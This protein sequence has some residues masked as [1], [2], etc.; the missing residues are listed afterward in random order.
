METSKYLKSK[1]YEL[2]SVLKVEVDHDCAFRSAP[3]VRLKR[4]QLLSSLASSG[5]SSC[6]TC[7]PQSRHTCAI[8]SPHKIS[9]HR[10]LNLGQFSKSPATAASFRFTQKLSRISA[11]RSQ[12]QSPVS[13]AVSNSISPGKHLKPPLIHCAPHGFQHRV[14]Q[15]GLD[16]LTT[17]Q[18]GRERLKLGHGQCPTSKKD[19]LGQ[20]SSS[21]V[22]AESLKSSERRLKE[23]RNAVFCSESASRTPVSETW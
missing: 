9:R 19:K 11:S 15:L 8:R 17:S 23:A 3:H 10:R 20:C 12:L 16:E 5:T 14:G 6:R 4:S 2:N 1:R 18:N 7:T 22:T 13:R 21:E